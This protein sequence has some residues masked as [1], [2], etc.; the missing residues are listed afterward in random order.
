MTPQRLR[1]QAQAV[2][3]EPL[4]MPHRNGSFVI[5]D[6]HFSIWVIGQ[7]FTAFD[8]QSAA[9]SLGFEREAQ[10]LWQ[11]K[12]YS[13]SPTNLGAMVCLSMASGMG[14]RED[15]MLQLIEDIRAMAARMNLFGTRVSDET[16]KTFHELPPDKFRASAAAAWGA[17]GWLTFYST[18]YAADPI[19]YPPSL[20]I[21]GDTN[22]RSG[23][24]VWPPH[25]VPNYLGQSMTNLYK[26]WPMIQDFGHVYDFTNPVPL[27]E[28]V[29]LSF[30]ESTYQKLLVWAT[31]L[32]LRMKRNEDSLSHVYFFH[33]L[34]HATIV[35]LFQPF[36]YSSAH[37]RLKSFNSR[38]CT[39]ASIYMAS[40][41]QLKR[42][43]IWYLTKAGRH[44][45]N[46]WF[47]VAVLQIMSATLWNTNDP[48]WKIY[49]QLCFNFWKEAYIR[50]RI[51]LK[52][53]RA[54]LYF[55][56]QLGVIERDTAVALVNE[57]RAVGAHH[58]DPESA[59]NS[60]IADHRM[61]AKHL[62]DS[63]VD[64]MAKEFADLTLSQHT[65]DV[66]RNTA[67]GASSKESEVAPSHN[68]LKTVLN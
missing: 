20:P 12:R 31:A 53:A 35:R 8:I 39:P 56:L 59:I 48:D 58:V 15:F 7:S 68:W 25:P 50:Y 21:P 44:S 64:T 42:L 38:D 60:A 11:D 36:L 63:R 6:S 14:G 62:T 67:D 23:G 41:R 17:Y 52:I 2:C 30:A 51:Y 43:L 10:L 28:R 3:P 19:A 1:R 4:S 13:D 66:E 5:P 37:T 54:N 49:F 22:R 61:A 40:M 55:A 46:G 27:S 18:H 45:D 57:L 24:L 29:T 33:A 26:L 32:D 9:L 47:T 16:L 34:Y 65:G